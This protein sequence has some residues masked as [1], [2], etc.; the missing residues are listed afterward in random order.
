MAERTIAEEIDFIRKCLRGV[1]EP[2][3]EPL[4]QMHFV[5]DAKE[6]LDRIEKLC[7][8]QEKEHE[9]LRSQISQLKCEMQEAA[10]L[11]NCYLQEIPLNPKAHNWLIR[12]GYKDESYQ[13]DI[14]GQ[15]IHK[16]R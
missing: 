6:S 7:A 5:R 3:L 8:E 4:G 9:G 14:Y 10:E 15:E 12:N 2:D 16:E 1:D 13:A 11:I